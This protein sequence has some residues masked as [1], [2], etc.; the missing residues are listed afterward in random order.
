MSCGNNFKQLG[1]G[2]HN[3]H[4]AYNQLPG[5]G[6][7][8]KRNFDG[9]T[10]YWWSGDN[11]SSNWRLSA[12]VGV[13]PFIEQQALWEQI[14]NQALKAELGRPW[15]RRLTPRPTFPGQP[16]YQPFDAQAILA[17]ACQLSD[18]PTMAFA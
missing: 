2:M 4:A 6:T 1:L 12:L 8:T 13:T 15:A 16:T 17:L 11:A 7:G 10:N 14:S 18:A 9:S 3:Y 5:H